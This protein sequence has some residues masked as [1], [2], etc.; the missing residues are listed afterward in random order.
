MMTRSERLVGGMER[1]A[2]SGYKVRVRFHTLGINSAAA[3]TRLGAD[4]TAADTG[5]Q[6]ITFSRDVAASD[7]ARFVRISTTTLWRGSLVSVMGFDPA[8]D[9]FIWGKVPR[10]LAREICRESDTLT[11]LDRWQVSGVVGFDDLTA[12][13][14]EIPVIVS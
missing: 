9:A 13:N 11:V 7:V 12:I 3:T 5:F 14:E 2:V 10:E 4:R 8:G 1:Q 6:A